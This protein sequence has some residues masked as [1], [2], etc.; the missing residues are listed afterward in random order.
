M[1]VCTRTHAE[2]VLASASVS[3]RRT[4]VG[5]ME[6]GGGERGLG[7]EGKVR[8]DRRDTRREMLEHGHSLLGA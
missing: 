6:G 5:R 3:E 7:E 4:A 2:G 8:R 1:Y